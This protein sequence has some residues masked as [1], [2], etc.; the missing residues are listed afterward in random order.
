MEHL[1]TLEEILNER[2][3]A[4]SFPEDNLRNTKNCL[5]HMLRSLIFAG[6]VSDPYPLL[7]GS[8]I[9]IQKEEYEPT[10]RKMKL[11]Y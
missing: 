10:L 11:I 1:P 5:D 7:I 6:N 3:L 4:E 8:R 2:D 9:A